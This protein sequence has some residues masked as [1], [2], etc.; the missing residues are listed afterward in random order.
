MKTKVIKIFSLLVFSCITIGITGC[1]KGQEQISKITD[2]D[3]VF[4]LEDIDEIADLED[5]DK[6][7]DKSK[8]FVA[9]GLEY[10]DEEEPAKA[11]MEKISE[12]TEE[13]LE[14]EGFTFEEEVSR[15]TSNYQIEIGEEMDNVYKSYYFKEDDEQDD[16]MLTVFV[17]WKKD[18]EELYMTGFYFDM[19]KENGDSEHLRKQL[20]KTIFSDDVIDGISDSY[21]ACMDGKSISYKDMENVNMNFHYSGRSVVAE[22][23]RETEDLNSEEIVYCV[24]NGEMHDKDGFFYVDEDG[25]AVIIREKEQG[26]FTIEEIDGLPVV[27]FVLNTEKL[28]EASCLAVASTVKEFGCILNKYDEEKVLFLPENVEVISS[29]AFYNFDQIFAFNPD[30]EY[31]HNVFPEFWD[32]LWTADEYVHL[33][34]VNNKVFKKFASEYE[35]VDYSEIEDSISEDFEEAEKYLDEMRVGNYTNISKYLESA[36]E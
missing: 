34:G 26:P 31:K 18:S 11:I 10:A 1:S 20:K 32:A 2:V 29:S 3:K 15:E 27:R 8:N 4:D 12:K 36:E 17:H 33:R 22:Y 24:Y 30:M 13:M 21:D 35:G 6:S 5:N 16:N 25:E 28:E 19:K 9:A 14:E 7:E 23:P